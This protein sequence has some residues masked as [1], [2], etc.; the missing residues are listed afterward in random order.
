MGLGSEGGVISING[1][2]GTGHSGRVPE[3][4]LIDQCLTN[5]AAGFAVLSF[6]T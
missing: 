1:L 2:Q 4:E 6:E 5:G 3:Q